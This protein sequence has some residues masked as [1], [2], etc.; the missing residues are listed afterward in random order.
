[1]NFLDNFVIPQP[2]YNLNLLNVFLVL[3]LTIFMV[4]SGILFGS[5][6]LSVYYKNKSKNF[7]DSYS[8]ISL[9][10]AGLITD[11]WIYGFGLGAVPFLS[12][13]FIY[14]QLLH[15]SEVAVVNYLTLSFVLY[16]AGMVL[17]FNYNKAFHL[18][19]VFDK[20]SLSNSDA[21]E[22][23]NSDFEAVNNNAK[24]KL[25]SLGNFSIILQIVAYWYLMAALSLAVHPNEWANSNFISI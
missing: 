8:R 20:V 25:N 17:A 3:G 5:I 9:E 24:S 16:I 22:K 6:I 11:K 15:K 13:I 12:V 23:T 4:Y 2:D 19:K 14:M 18:A 7:N 10:Y 1:M 21:D